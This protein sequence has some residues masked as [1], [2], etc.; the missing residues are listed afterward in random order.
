M[1][2]LFL[3][4]L[5]IMLVLACSHIAVAEE[6]AHA[7][8]VAP[9]P[10]SRWYP[11]ADRY[12]AWQQDRPL[13]LAAL[14]NSVPRDHLAERTE[15]FKA[16]GLNTLIWWK[17]ANALHV[18]EAAHKAGLE[19]ACGSVGGTK[20]ITAAMRIPGCSFVMAGDEPSRE[21][22][23]PRIAAIADWVQKK[24]PD[25]PVFSNLSIS[26]IDHDLYVEKCRPDVFSFDHYPLQRDGQTHDHYLYNVAWGLQTVRKYRLPYW[27][28]LQAYGREASSPK[29]AYRV[30]DEADLRFLVFSFLAHGG[31][32]I[33]FFHYYGYQ[34]AM[35]DDLAV[36]EEGRAPSSLHKYENTVVSRAWHAVRG[37]APEV[38][39][40]GRALVNLRCTGEVVYSGNGMLWDRKPP[41]YSRHNP[42]V[43]VECRRFAG[44]GLLKAVGVTGAHDMGLLIS[45]FQD[46][47][48]EE[49]FMVV[50]LMHGKNMS[51]S[52]GMRAVQ[53]SFTGD[54]E[55]IE[56]LNRFTGRVEVLSTAPAEGEVRS[57][58]VHLEGGTGDLFKW[59]NGRAWHL[60]G[61]K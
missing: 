8:E 24:H 43:P 60:R 29:Y 46:K 17:P 13:L 18:F 16:A 42:K 19:W 56:R 34:G 39:N 48:G 1:R 54:V 37:V 25:K 38:Q 28:L 49:Y 53:L 58:V 35:V 6:G 14:H 2:K 59:H 3:A 12:N 7:A 41:T 50:N 47:S 36:A 23:L 22:E 51:K 10:G 5:V 31:T 61:G 33:M 26:K 57:L 45:F 27:M 44:H 4:E 9:K 20:A 32:G 30:P 52:G 55:K 11:Y 15:R 21:D 40:L